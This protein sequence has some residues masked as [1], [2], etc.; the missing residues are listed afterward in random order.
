M[1]QK[2]SSLRVLYWT[3]KAVRED[4]TPI[5]QTAAP[6]QPTGGRFGA[7]APAP[8]SCRRVINCD[9]RWIRGSGGWKQKVLGDWTSP[10]P[11]FFLC[12]V[13]DNGNTPF[14]TVLQ[15]SCSKADGENTL[16]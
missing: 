16:V 11:F 10:R 13:Q 3:H 1:G 4:K 12:W 5:S 15:H 8:F 9:A 14:L 6:A 7:A 2:V